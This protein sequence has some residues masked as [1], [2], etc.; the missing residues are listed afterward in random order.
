MQIK[1]LCVTSLEELLEEL[2]RGF[3]NVQNSKLI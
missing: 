1:S 3:L 2:P